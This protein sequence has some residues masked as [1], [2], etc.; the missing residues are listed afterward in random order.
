M[1]DTE[2]NKLKR[3]VM[4]ERLKSRH[5]E[6]EYADDEAIYGQIL[7]DLDETDK[8]LTTRREA[9]KKLGDMFLRDE[10]SAKFLMD[11]RDGGD[12]MI[13]LI[14]QFGTDIKEAIDDP[15]RMEEIAQANKEYVERVAQE[16]EL[17]E[18]YQSNLAQSLE[19]LE[20][21]QSESGASDEDIDDAME[22]LI[23]IVSD[24]L[25]GKFSRESVIMALKAIRHDGDVEAASQEGEI[26]GRN[27]KIEAKLRKPSKGDG[28]PILNGASG[29]VAPDRPDLGALGRMD[30]GVDDIWERGAIKRNKHQ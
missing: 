28:T 3:D 16:K 29:R 15:D 23:S 12:P 14:R 10:R 20:Q 5:P 26:R 13:A 1:A 8:E 21:Y 11:W 19:M 17:E 24:G 25:M 4:L 27:A 6:A 2:S 18:T 9:D 22:L 30:S 7:D